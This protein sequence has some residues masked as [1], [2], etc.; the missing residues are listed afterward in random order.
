MKKV[1][2]LFLILLLTACNS[3]PKTTTDV[4]GL[5]PQSTVQPTVQ[6]TVQTTVQSTV[7]ST[8]Q[9]TVQSPPK[10]DIKYPNDPGWKVTF[11]EKF[12]NKSKIF[13]SLLP[14]D[15]KY[16][17]GESAIANGVYTTTITGKAGST[18]LKAG[19]DNIPLGK[20]TNIYIGISGK[21]NSKFK[22]SGWGI[23]LLADDDRNSYVNFALLKDSYGLYRHNKDAYI[24]DD[25]IDAKVSDK[26]KIGQMNSMELKIDG[27]FLYYFVNG[28]SMGFYNL[29]EL[30]YPGTNLYLFYVADEGA[31]ATFD[32]DNFVVEVK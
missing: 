7:Q 5:T 21:I 28:K 27:D 23:G 29:S 12:D 22:N 2:T 20:A 31:K 9:P 1:C 32:I 4:T 25:K 6:S 24:I 14:F 17:S 11:C 8:V 3:T 15:G 13:W 18:F 30:Q 16:I 26:I 19:T 10:C